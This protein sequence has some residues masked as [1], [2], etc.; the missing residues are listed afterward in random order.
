MNEIGV[1]RTILNYPRG[2]SV[3]R[4]GHEFS[5]GYMVAMQGC[6]MVLDPRAVNFSDVADHIEQNADM[7][8]DPDT[9]VG[10]WLHQ[11]KIYLEPA[12]H[13]RDFSQA[14]RLG[15]QRKQIAIWDV[16]RNCIVFL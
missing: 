11:G 9:H 2:F 1:I 16:L 8:R 4:S 6:T 14:C 13:V 12:Q 5:S 10:G 7:Y 15:K 3:S